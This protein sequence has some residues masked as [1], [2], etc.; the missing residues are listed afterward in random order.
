[1]RQY[2]AIHLSVISTIG[3]FGLAVRGSPQLKIVRFCA[4]NLT[5]LII[6]TIW[7]IEGSLTYAVS[8]TCRR[9]LTQKPKSADG[10][11]FRGATGVHFRVV[12]AFLLLLSGKGS[13]LSR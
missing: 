7:T 12:P 13:G 9:A 4:A 1:M 10:T 11:N 8:T 6:L 2:P 3:T 5:F